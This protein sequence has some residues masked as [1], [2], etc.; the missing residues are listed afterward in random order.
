VGERASKGKFLDAQKKNVATYL[1]YLL[2]ARPNFLVAQGLLTTESKV[3]FLV[4]IGS[5][6]I[7]QLKV[8]WHNKNLYKVIQWAP[9]VLQCFT[10][11]DCLQC[12]ALWNGNHT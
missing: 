2:L 8:K 10:V 12:G 4:G 3:M 7:W 9:K 6:S 5:I 1:H 11:S